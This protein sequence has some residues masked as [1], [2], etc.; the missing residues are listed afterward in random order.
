VGVTDE[1]SEAS[2]PFPEGLVVVTGAGGFVGTAL[3]AHFRERGR[4]F[5]GIVRRM[6]D[7][8]PRDFEPVG[9]MTQL[10]DAL[11]ED[12]VGDAHAVVH[13][14]GRAHV[15]VEAD[16]NPGRA[17]SLANEDLTARLAAI[18]ARSGVRRFILASTVKVNGESTPPGRPFRPD[19]P[20]NPQDAYAR[21][22]LAAEQALFAAAS[23]STMTAIALRLP[24]VYGRNAKG[25]FSQLVQAVAAGRRLPF[26]SIR[27]RRNLLYAGNLVE[28]I[29]A[30]IATPALAGVHFVADTEAVATPDL[31]RAIAFAWRVKPQLVAMPVPLLRL[32]GLAA[33]RSTVVARLTDSLEVDTASFRAAT[34]WAPRWPLDAALARIASTHRGAPPF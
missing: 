33:G 19:D 31:V 3:C 10:T 15:M 1:R 7:D 23:G 8:L 6:R 29:D 26:A 32:C 24:L 18:A 17:Y 12:I 28:A 4:P 13:L 25:N 16:R 9:D 27:N 11:L 14:A 22:K 30:A 5:I 21:S 20:P 2:E 34:R